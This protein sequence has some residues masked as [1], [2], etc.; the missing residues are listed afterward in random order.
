[1]GGKINLLKKQ[2]C[3][4]SKKVERLQDADL[5]AKAK[6]EEKEKYLATKEEQLSN[7]LVDLKVAREEIL[8]KQSE[9]VQ[10]ESH[11]A[12]LSVKEN[13]SASQLKSLKEANRQ[14]E[15]QIATLSEK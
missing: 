3:Q 2:V 15:D 5:A 10:H 4:L 1:M 13:E 6:M 14:L 9:I 7:T 8:T 12:T 11:I